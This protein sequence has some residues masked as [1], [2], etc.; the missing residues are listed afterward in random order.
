MTPK[1]VRR[2][3]IHPMIYALRAQRELLG[4]SQHELE[5][6]SGLSQGM[7]SNME[8]GITSDPG[9]NTLARYADTVGLGIALVVKR[10]AAIPRGRLGRIG[11]EERV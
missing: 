9:I 4:I 2:H 10:S 11:D 7:I 6:R 3:E 1:P 8:S 5:E